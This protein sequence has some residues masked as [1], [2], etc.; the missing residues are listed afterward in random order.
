[1]LPTDRK[2]VGPWR[3]LVLLLAA[4]L[5]FMFLLWALQGCSTEE[6]YPE[7]TRTAQSAEAALIAARYLNVTRR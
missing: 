3:L 7:V 6:P 5:M 2:S 1:M 4:I